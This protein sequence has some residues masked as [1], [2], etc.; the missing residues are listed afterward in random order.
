MTRITDYAILARME[1]IAPP[2]PRTATVCLAFVGK[3][4]TEV[5]LNNS[6]NGKKDDSCVKNKCGK[7]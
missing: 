2:L 1:H 3:I 5:P 7:I 4:L 6:I